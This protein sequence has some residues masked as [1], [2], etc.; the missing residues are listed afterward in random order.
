[1]EVWRRRK[2]SLFPICFLWAFV[3][4][5][6]FFTSNSGWIQF[7]VCPTH[8]QPD[9]IP[10]A[11]PVG[12][13]GTRWLV[14]P[15]T[16][17]DPFLWTW[18]HQVSWAEPP[19]LSSDI[20]VSASWALPLSFW[21]S[22]IQSDPLFHQPCFLKVLPRDTF[23]FPPCLFSDGPLYTSPH[24]LILNSIWITSVISASECIPSDTATQKNFIHLKIFIECPYP[25]EILTKNDGQTWI[26]W[27]V[28][29]SVI[30]YLCV[31][32]TLKLFPSMRV[33]V[34]LCSWWL[35]VGDDIWRGRRGGKGEKRHRIKGEKLLKSSIVAK[36]KSIN[37]K[38]F[39]KK[40]KK[41]KGKMYHRKP[42]LKKKKKE[43]HF[44]LTTHSI[45]EAFFFFFSPT[46]T[47]S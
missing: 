44:S 30:S 17:L 11:S 35:M 3:L 10:L 46:N 14:T 28:T 20:C 47:S 4:G 7:K 9:C 40:K 6:P 21:V 38:Y 26:L 34:M 42:L 23:G 19:A 41:C 36:N 24:F 22:V 37:Q 18:R 8:K 15:L 31:V 16:G 12:N 43:N 32:C 33:D 39:P 5:S 2:D 45:C 29:V 27:P 25:S 13:T 1:M